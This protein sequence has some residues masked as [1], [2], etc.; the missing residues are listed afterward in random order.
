MQNLV[1]G[2]VIGVGIM[3]LETGKISGS[4]FRVYRRLIPLF[5]IGKYIKSRY[6][7]AVISI[8]CFFDAPV[9]ISKVTF[10]ISGF[11]NGYDQ[12]TGPDPVASV[13]MEVRIGFIVAV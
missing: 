13:S 9:F 7:F 3:L 1:P 8:L 11:R 5:Q 2:F 6:V 10:F 4:I 12:F